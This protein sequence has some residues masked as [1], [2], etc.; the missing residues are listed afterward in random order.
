MRSARVPEAG[1]DV[2]AHVYSQPDRHSNDSSIAD[3]RS[4]RDAN[5]NLDAESNAAAHSNGHAH[6][7]VGLLQYPS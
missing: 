1:S 6:N 7:S 5:R 3:D 4:Q 2:N